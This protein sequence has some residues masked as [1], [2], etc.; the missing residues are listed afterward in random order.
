MGDK[1]DKTKAETVNAGGFFRAEQGM[2][3]YGWASGADVIQIH[4]MGPFPITYVN[5]A[6]DPRNKPARRNNEHFA[7]SRAGP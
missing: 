2:P 7:S 5:P 6:D 4:G 1:L 3:H